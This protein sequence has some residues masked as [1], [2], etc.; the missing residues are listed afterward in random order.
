MKLLNK[1]LVELM[2]N[3]YYGAPMGTIAQLHGVSKVTGKH[4]DG[5]PIVEQIPYSFGKGVRLAIAL[6]TK[7]LLPFSEAL[8]E[9]CSGI[10]KQYEKEA[11]DKGEEWGVEHSRYSECIEEMNELLKQEFEV[12]S[13]PKFKIEDLK[14]DDNKLRSSIIVSLLPF[15]E[16]DAEKSE[17]KSD[18][19]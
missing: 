7:K 12:P 1:Q 6:I 9:A 17:V 18:E 3:T 2:G 8:N 4:E 19:E 14:I 15:F 10:V 16:K 5:K 11:K 13:M